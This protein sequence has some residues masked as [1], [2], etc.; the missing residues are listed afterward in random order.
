M[1]TSIFFLLFTV[2]ELFSSTII[3]AKHPPSQRTIP[4]T[5]LGLH[6]EKLTHLHFY[7]HDVISGPR[8]T[9]VNVAQA[10]MTDKSPTKFGAVVMADE[11][12]TLGPE[13][14]SKLVGKAQGMYASASQNDFGLMMVMNFEF[15]EGKYNGSTMSLLGRN[16]AISAVREM[17]IVGGS[18]LFRFS[19]GYALAKTYSF[20]VTTLNAIVEYN[21]YV[22]HY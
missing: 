14:E 3:T 13:P 10:P 6:Q 5:S 15:L 2:F 8:P 9:A 12:L 7:F 16:A 4:P 21:V 18:G 22:F 20:N 1:T 11:P 17:P 19:R